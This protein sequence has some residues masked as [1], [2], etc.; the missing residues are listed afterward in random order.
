[1][2]GIH[3]FDEHWLASKEMPLALTLRLVVSDS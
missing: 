3:L 1:M 2:D